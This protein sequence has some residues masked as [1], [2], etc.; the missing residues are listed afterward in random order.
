MF[1]KGIYNFYNIKIIDKIYYY[2]NIYGNHIETFKF[3]SDVNY[4][5]TYIGN[6]IIL[7]EL[8][9]NEKHFNKS[10]NDEKLNNIMG[11]PSGKTAGYSTNTYRHIYLTNKHSNNIELKQDMI[12]MGSSMYD[13][14]YYIKKI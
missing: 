11:V 6:V 13:T 8:F 2:D 7:L 5:N 3:S 10:S 9:I 14:K 1:N 12:N 4:N